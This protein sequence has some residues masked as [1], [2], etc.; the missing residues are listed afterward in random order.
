LGHRRDGKRPSLECPEVVGVGSVSGGGGIYRNLS[1]A[2]SNAA[3]SPLSPDS[4]W[5]VKVI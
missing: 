2:M 3:M 1:D 5:R 4:E